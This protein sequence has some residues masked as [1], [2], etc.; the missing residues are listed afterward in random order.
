MKREGYIP[1]PE[2][3]LAEGLNFHTYPRAPNSTDTA[4]Q[5]PARPPA[6]QAN[7][8][9]Q[10]FRRRIAAQEKTAEI[11][12]VHRAHSSP[13]SPT[14]HFTPFW[15]L[16]QNNNLEKRSN[17][18]K[19]SCRCSAMTELNEAMK[20]MQCVTRRSVAKVI[21][22]F[23]TGCSDSAVVHCVPRLYRTRRQISCTENKNL[24]LLSFGGGGRLLKRQA[25]AQRSVLLKSERRDV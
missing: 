21:C 20:R 7:V 18:A 10:V 6:C 23:V 9:A 2:G 16:A 1:Q 3:P 25:A 12:T 19:F 13:P 22:L 17:S 14:L 4:E 15:S 8:S 24:N 11:A 5:P